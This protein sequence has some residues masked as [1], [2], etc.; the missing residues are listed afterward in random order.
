MV[1]KTE[2]STVVA[3]A[4]EDEEE[5]IEAVT[6]GEVVVVAGAHEVTHRTAFRV[7]TDEQGLT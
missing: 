5:A 2:A 6:R 1:D 3:V 4:V 7:G